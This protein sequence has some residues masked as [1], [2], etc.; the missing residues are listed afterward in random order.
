M[1]SIVGKWPPLKLK[2]LCLGAHP[3]DIEYGVGG[4]LLLLKEKYDIN[5]LIMTCGEIGAPASIRKKEQMCSSEILNSKIYWGGSKDTKITVDRITITKI[6][7]VI[8]KIKPDII[9][10]NYY[11]DTHQDH[12][13]ASFATL[14]ASRY[15]RN[16]L[17]YEVPTS[18]DFTPNIFMNIE[19]VINNKMELLRTHKSQVNAT[20]IPHLN[21]LESVKSCAVFRGF[22]NR[23]KY[24]EGF[25]SIRF[26]LDYFI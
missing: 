6:E 9:F 22:Q 4:T 8:K 1:Q 24:A 16:V 7:V 10:V 18:I 19:K 2:I 14:T 20:R 21:I 13:N 12:R 5:M 17:L 15:V 11:N 26:S 23:V 25:L 3:D